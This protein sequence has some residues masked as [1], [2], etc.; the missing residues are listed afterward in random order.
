MTDQERLDRIDALKAEIARL[1]AGEKARWVLT[2][3][4]DAFRQ[5][6]EEN[7]NPNNALEDE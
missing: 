7:P 5:Q 6:E 2:P 1:E 3:K 4:G